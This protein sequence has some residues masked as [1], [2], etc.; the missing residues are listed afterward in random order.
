MK[1]KLLFCLLFTFAFSSCKILRP[2][3]IKMNGEYDG[4]EQLT[5]TNQTKKGCSE[6]KGQKYLIIHGIGS[7][8]D[9]Y[10]LKMIQRISKYSFKGVKYK[11]EF[12]CLRGE[13]F[14]RIPGENLEREMQDSTLA[15]NIHVLKVLDYS[16]KRNGE[17]YSKTNTFY[18]INWSVLAKVNKKQLQKEEFKNGPRFIGIN[19]GILKKVVMMEKVSDAFNGSKPETIEEL[20][21]II[22]V[23]FLKEQIDQEQNINLISGSFGSQLFIGSM[24]ILKNP[25]LLKNPEF[26]ANS[27][28]PI[29]PNSLLN[30]PLIKAYNEP[31]NLAAQS[32]IVQ[33]LNMFLLTNQI[34]LMDEN[35]LGWFKTKSTDPLLRQNSLDYEEVQIVAFRN[36][37]DIL[38]YYLPKKVV[39]KLFENF[40]EPEKIKVY[41]GYYFNWP[42]RNDVALAHTSVFNLKK[43]AKAI[44][45]G[46][47][48][49]G[50]KTKKVRLFQRD[51][52]PSESN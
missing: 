27:N 40:V 14:V 31:S 16:E 25:E 22:L 29:N 26:L 38:C 50:V 44:Y 18:S 43:L 34:N 1:H 8:K 13:N 36:P 47:D 19:K 49:W 46:M 7:Q 11:R 6:S 39:D 30:N 12:Y 5:C 35:I 2:T 33:K 4:I 17:K 32:K 15:G 10:S 41:N 48:A 3:R 42:I 51:L 20:I 37:N 28:L 23:L 9:N 24:I 45:Y 52:L 21:N